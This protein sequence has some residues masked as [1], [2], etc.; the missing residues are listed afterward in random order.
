MKICPNCGAEND[1]NALTCILCEFE[2]DFENENSE[3]GATANNE[4][5]VPDTDSVDNPSGKDDNMAPKSSNK[6]ILIAIASALVVFLGVGGIFLMMNKDDKKSDNSSNNAPIATTSNATST[7]KTETTA[8]QE[9]ATETTAEAS[10]STVTETSVSS[11]PATEN[12]TV[13]TTVTETTITGNKIKLYPSEKINDYPVYLEKLKDLKDNGAYHDQD[14]GF[15]LCDINGDSI[16]ELFVT[17]N[18]TEPGILFAGSIYSGELVTFAEFMGAGMLRG[19]TLF[20]NGVIGI[21]S[22]G[23]TGHGVTYIQYDGG[24]SLNGQRESISYIYENGSLSY[25]SYQNGTQEK[26]ISEAE[27]N[28]IQKKY[29]EASYTA[30]PVSSVIDTVNLPD[31]PKYIGEGYVNTE[32]TGLNLRSEPNPNSKILASIPKNAKIDCYESGVNGWYI[33][34]YKGD[35]GYV[36]SEF[37]SMDSNGSSTVINGVTV[38]K[39]SKSG[40]INTHGGNLPSITLDYITGGDWKTLRDS[41]GNGWHI[42]A[43][44]YCNSKGITWYEIEDADGGDY[45]GWIDGEFIDFD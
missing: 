28:E 22:G 3:T 2:F 12:T 38:Y 5:V 26:Y 39:C 33:T 20:D 16:P 19:I 45:Y 37:I 29:V 8:T 34:Y 36:S 7:E 6:P 32:S 27:A 24:D 31:N 10:S 42:K 35:A 30:A 40:R 44:R 43:T 1:D 15:F 18:T 21:T 41:L 17:F 23:N 4:N 9:S 25:I 11:E 14:N 13:N